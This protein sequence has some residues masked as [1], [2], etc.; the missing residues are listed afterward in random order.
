MANWRDEYF[1]A[2]VVRDR[3]D[4]A[5]TTLFDACM[6]KIHRSS[7]LHHLARLINA[8]YLTT[9]LLART[10]TRLADRS[11]QVVR[12]ETP[13]TPSS[14]A[15]SK[16]GPGPGPGQLEAAQSLQDTLAAVRSDLTAAQ[17]SRTELQDRLSRTTT[18]LEKLKKKSIQDGRRIAALE[19]E[20]THLQLRLKDRDEELRGKA[21]LLDVRCTRPIS[22]YSNG[23]TGI[24]PVCVDR[25]MIFAS[26]RP[27]SN[28]MFQ[29]LTFCL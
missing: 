5:N 25:T 28:K 3:R 13:R 17:Q 18:D 23:T 10:D 1:A 20:R 22:G 21:K 16:R 26:H 9:P 8:S 2:L 19:G 4:Q 29:M 7:V 24:N 12:P 15:P 6:Q 11:V 27:N 14:P